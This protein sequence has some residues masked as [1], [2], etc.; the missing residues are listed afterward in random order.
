M[1]WLSDHPLVA[2]FDSAANHP[3]TPQEVAQQS[4]T[5]VH[6]VCGSGH[7]WPASPDNRVSMGS[8]CPDCGGTP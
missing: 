7:R 1:G 8:G 3:L 4:N 5:K 6:R 2:D